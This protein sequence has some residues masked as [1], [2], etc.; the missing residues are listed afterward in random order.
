[1]RSLESTFVKKDMEVV[2]VGRIVYFVLKEVLVLARTSVDSVEDE[3][4]GK[5]VCKQ[6]N[7]RSSF[8]FKKKFKIP[9][10]HAVEANNGQ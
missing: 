6:R 1:M 9:V 8:C 2:A 5:N 7:G 10:H 3:I 4:F